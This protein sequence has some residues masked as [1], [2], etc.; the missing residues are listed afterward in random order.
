MVACCEI[1][2]YMFALL[3][4]SATAVYSNMLQYVK[5]TEMILDA[6]ERTPARNMR[7]P[8]SDSNK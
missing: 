7:I 6:P 1:Y 5:Y 2:A 4:G 8:M 3:K